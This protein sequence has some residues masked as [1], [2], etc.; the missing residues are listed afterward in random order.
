M[1]YFTICLNKCVSVHLL[2]ISISRDALR[3]KVA[4]KTPCRNCA[5][6][7]RGTYRWHKD[8]EITLILTETTEAEVAFSADVIP[9]ICH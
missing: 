6:Y 5:V 8:P 7:C 1:V 9:E 3:V 2:K 4:G